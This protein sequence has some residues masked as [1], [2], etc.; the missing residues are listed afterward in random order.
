V[1]QQ[2]MGEGLVQFVLDWCI[3]T[4]G[5]L[6]ATLLLVKKAMQSHKAAFIMLV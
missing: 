5:N 3:A 1:G 4:L 2:G 6:Q